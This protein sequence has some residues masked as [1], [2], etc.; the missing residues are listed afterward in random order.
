MARPSRKASRNELRDKILGLGEN[1]IRKNYYPQLQARI[2]ELRRAEEKMRT[3]FNAT[4][5]AIFI[6]DGDGGKILDVNESAVKMYGVSKEQFLCA[7]VETLG[8]RGESATRDAALQW[9]RDVLSRGGRIVEWT[10]RHADGREFWVEA[11]LS[12]ETL[13]G[14]E[15]VVIVVRD[16]HDRKQA[17]E[18]LR[19]SEARFEV[20]ASAARIGVWEFDLATHTF[21]WDERMHALYGTDP[22]AFGGT[23]GDWLACVHPD[24]AAAIKK[25]I[26]SHEVAQDYLGFRIVRA[27][28]SVRH[29]RSFATHVTPVDGESGR[30]IGVNIDVTDE[31]TREEQLRQSQ[32]ME[33]V[34][35]LAG[36][37][38]HDFNNVLQVQI[39]LSEL[40]MDELGRDSEQFDW[41]QEMRRT[42]LQAMEITRQLLAFSRKQPIRPRA[43]DLNTI[44]RESQV[45]L[46]LLLGKKVTLS[47]DLADSLPSV[48]VDSGQVTQVIMNLSV[49]ARDAMAGRGVIEIS[50]RRV[51]LGSGDAA[52]PDG[53]NPGLFVCLSVADNGCGMDAETQ[54]H[55]F[56][57]FFTTKEV[58]KGTGLGLSV[59]NDIVQQNRGWIT[60]SS[61]A[62]HGTTFFIYFPCSEQ[63]SVLV[64]ATADE[65]FRPEAVGF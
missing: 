57:P 39:G 47:L 5:D 37:I 44:A 11:S 56:E 46:R 20:A 1:S 31:I 8:L 23:Y 45:L 15:C 59:V 21:I 19:K 27:D 51:E 22:S 49:N 36:G 12:V 42:S 62:E 28:G 25:L 17:E 13:S 4:H 34:G 58:G 55:L 65:K 16:I 24:D 10:S 29:I 33:A 53:C 26:G 63:S 48:C 52:L 61:E 60:V 7:G 9:I 14:R 30:I 64:S 40:L 43:L 6:V 2:E 50:T 3:I 35:Q 41:A 32:K 38:A 54:K 18:K